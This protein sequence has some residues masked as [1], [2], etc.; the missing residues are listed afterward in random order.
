MATVTVQSSEVVPGD[1]KHVFTRSSRMF[2]PVRPRCLA[3][4]NYL[5]PQV[6]QRLAALAKRF[7]SKTQTV[8]INHDGGAV[9]S[10]RPT[11]TG[12]RRAEDFMANYFASGLGARPHIT[13]SPGHSFSDLDG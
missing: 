9:E 1:R 2:D 4:T 11:Q 5:M 8:P 6:D 10:D 13:V 12:R 7:N 3:K